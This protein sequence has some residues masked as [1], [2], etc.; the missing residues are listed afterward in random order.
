[1]DGI[2]RPEADKATPTQSADHQTSNQ[3]RDDLWLPTICFLLSQGMVLSFS[4]TLCLLIHYCNHG[5]AA[6]DGSSLMSEAAVL[7]LHID[8]ALILF[9]QC[10]M[11]LQLFRHRLPDRMVDMTS[12][13]TLAGV[14]DFLVGSLVISACVHALFCYV[15]IAKDAMVR[16]RGVDGFSATVFLTGVGWTGH[17]MLVL[18][19][20]LVVM[21]FS[22]HRVVD[23]LTFTIRRKLCLLLGILGVLHGCFVGSGLRVHQERMGGLMWHFAALGA[24]IYLMEMVLGFLGSFRASS[25]SRIIQHPSNVVEIQIQPK[26][27]MPE[28]GQVS[29]CSGVVYTSKVNGP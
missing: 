6:I 7:I 17:A 9:P 5:T 28:I 25:I 19:A 1:M 11:I 29:V 16:Q 26:V 24:L 8:A 27:V 13:I 14:S 23:L 15:L 4:V 18:M 20:G 12:W 21:L 10:P 22:K 2:E 3:D